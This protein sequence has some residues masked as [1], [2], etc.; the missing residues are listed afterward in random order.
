MPD[1][2]PVAV[3]DLAFFAGCGGDDDARLRRGARR[4]APRRSDGR[5][6]S[7]PESRGHRP[8]P[9][10]SP[11]RCG[12]GPSASAISSRY[13][14]HALALG[15]RPG[16]GIARRV[17]GHLVPGGRF[18][19]IRVGGHLRRKWPV[20]TAG[21]GG[22]LRRGGRFWRPD[23]RPSAPT[24]HRNAGR[25]QVV[26]GRFAP[27]PGGVLRCAAA[28]SPVAPAPRLAAVLMSSKTLL[29]AAKEH[30]AP[31]RRQRLGRYAWWP[32]F[33]CPSMAGFGCPPRPLRRGA[34]AFEGA[35]SGVC[36]LL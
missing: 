15:A 1:H 31:R 13:G 9:A 19:P 32:V 5:W 23:P 34:V 33:R 17:G 29:M 11:S 2:R 24:A 26:A 27:D 28:T 14:S 21:V 35:Q 22:H 25:F 8:G 7:A 20:L 18:W 30:T 10:R 3:I 6:R 4:A 36:A 16:C 12:H